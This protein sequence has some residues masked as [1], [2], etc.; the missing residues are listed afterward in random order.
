MGSSGK[1]IPFIFLEWGQ[2]VSRCADSFGPKVTTRD[3]HAHVIFGFVGSSFCFLRQTETESGQD[4]FHWNPFFD[5]LIAIECSQAP[6]DR[7]F[8]TCPEYEKWKKIFHRAGYTPHD[9]GKRGLQRKA[10]LV[11]LW[12]NSTKGGGG[13]RMDLTTKVRKYDSRDFDDKSA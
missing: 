6:A 4:H 10:L 9:P 5:P 8:E 1:K 12:N 11:D 7:V 3:S 13:T 2:L